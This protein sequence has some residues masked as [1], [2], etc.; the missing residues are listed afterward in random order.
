MFGYVKIYKPELKI[1]DYEAYKAVYCSLCK[2]LGHDYGITARAFLS[3]DL[4]FFVLFK[5]AVAQEEC[6]SYKSG[7]CKFNPLKKC[8]YIVSDDEILSEAA[9]LTIIMAYYKVK[10]NIDDSKGLK[11]FLYRM[12]YPYIKRKYKKAK[13]KYSDLENLIGECM[14]NQLAAEQQKTSSVDMAAD[15]SAKALGIVFSY[16]VKDEQTRRV[17][18]RF[19]YCLGRWVYLSDAFDDIPKDLKTGNYNPFILKYK[20]K[21]IDFDEEAI[22]KTLNLTAN[23]TAMAFNLLDLKHYKDI[24]ENVVYDGLENQQKLIQK[25]RGEQ[26][27]V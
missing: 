6:D 18:E 7:R 1:K 13:A 2:K 23:E 9:A 27:D 10:D 3:Y 8:N 25:K 26:A 19:G 24:L 5:K 22:I 12:I 11:K 17:C 16:E 21:N 14:K 15:Q 20:I 4:T